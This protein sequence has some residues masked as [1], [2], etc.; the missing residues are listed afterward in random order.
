MDASVI[1]LDQN[2]SEIDIVSFKQLS[3][4]DGAIQHGGDE[5]EGDEEG[6]DEQI[7]LALDR[8]NPAATY[9]G[10]CVNSYSGESLDK[11]AATG[12]HVFHTRTKL[13]MASFKM[14]GMADL[15][16]K[17]ALL[18]GIL[19]RDPQDPTEWLLHICALP[20]NGIVVANNVSTL[21]SY[22]TT[23][24]KLIE[25]RTQAYFGLGAG[26]RNPDSEL[27]MKAPAMKVVVACFD[28]P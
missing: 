23:Q 2:L 17:T 1:V 3:S 4:K 9:L 10:F 28:C 8:V 19:Y 16:H 5:R 25:R 13:D 7:R 27:A 18:V 21:Q 6:D 11:V 12:C 14:T 20:A 15:R 24:P 26:S 22:I